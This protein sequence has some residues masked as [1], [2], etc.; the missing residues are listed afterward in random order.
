MCL[1]AE[2]TRRRAYTTPMRT[3]PRQLE[4][5]GPGPFPR[6]GRG[7]R[8]GD[9][10]VGRT[11]RFK[12]QVVDEYRWLRRRKAEGRCDAP[13]REA[14]ARF[15][16]HKSLVCKWAAQEAALRRA[17]ERDGTAAPEP[18]RRWRA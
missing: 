8:Q 7:L 13:L 3:H 16:V 15:G 10:R 2:R 6:S 9:R 4:D 14:A 12:L 18:A 1:R 17:V 5:G 11:L